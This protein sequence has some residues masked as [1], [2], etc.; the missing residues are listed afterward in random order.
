MPVAVLAMSAPWLNKIYAWCDYLSS[1]D[2]ST[3]L[4]CKVKRK[5]RSWRT[6]HACPLKKNTTNTKGGVDLAG[7]LRALYR[8]T[9]VKPGIKEFF[10][11]SVW[12]RRDL[13]A[14]NANSGSY[15][16]LL[17]FKLEISDSLLKKAPEKITAKH[18]HLI[19]PRCLSAECRCCLCQKTSRVR[20]KIC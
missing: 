5:I 11:P 9:E 7:M 16:N 15:K 19:R 20:Q 4:M 8:S 2:V 13:S 6:F 1:T 18:S 17:Q 12:L 14:N 10:G 3:Q